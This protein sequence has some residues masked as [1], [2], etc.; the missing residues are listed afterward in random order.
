[1]ATL[2]VD[3]VVAGGG[4]AGLA[5]ALECADK[6]KKVILVAPEGSHVDTDARTTAL[7]MPSIAMLERYGVWGNCQKEA[8]PLR[9]LRIIDDTNRFL[10]AP[11]VD[12]HASEIGEDAFGYNIPNQSLNSA[13]SSAVLESKSISVLSGMV[14]SAEF[15]DKYARVTLSDGNEIEAQLVI[16]ADGVNSIVRQAA[17]IDVRRWEYRQTACVMAFD[18]KRPHENT[19]TEFHTPEGPF[20]QVPLPGNRSSLVWVRRPEDAEDI[21]ALGSAALSSAI[22]RQMQS[23]LG[24]VSNP[25]KVQKWPLSSMVAAKF[26]AR[27]V[28]LIGQAAHAFPPIGA[29]GLNL[30]FR[31]IDDLGVAMARSTGDSGS[32]IVTTSYDRKRR[33]DVY[34]RTGAV[35]LLNRSLLSG[36]APLQVGRA[37]GLNVL[38]NSTLLRGVFMKEGIRP[39]SSVGNLFAGKDSDRNNRP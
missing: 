36:F 22:E 8:A 39:G 25:T 17:G 38:K 23:L 19:S 9:V 18:H 34:L 28:A 7:M 30:G 24:K 13:L 29:Q 5:V 32:P 14:S 16:G 6:G 21:S 35:D 10:R 11:N 12:F 37:L 1:M 33:A 31:D 26:S 27:R 15:S 2:E 20:T 3:I 4:P